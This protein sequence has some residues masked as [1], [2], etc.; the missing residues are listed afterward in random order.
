M[1]AASAR[2]HDILRV[3]IKSFQG[4][5]VQATTLHE[6]GIFADRAFALRDKESGKILSGKHARKG[7]RLLEFS[8]RF[9]REPVVGETLPPII[10][11]IAG[12]ECSTEDLAAFT[13]RCAEALDGDVELVVAGDAG[14]VY[15]TY[16]PEVDGLPLS[17]STIEFP[18]GLAEV[19]SFADLEPLHLL[20]TASIAHL[21]SLLP[22][23]EVTDARFRPSLVLD[24][25]DATGFVENDWVGRTATLGGATLALGQAAPRCVMT[26]RPQR[27]LPKD[28]RVLRTLVQENQQEF[29]GLQMPCLG[30]Y[31]KVTQ[32][33]PISVGD[34][35][36]IE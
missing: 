29:M 8:A 18:L 35:L 3:P 2:V 6:S 5:A 27:G 21:A 26:T 34:E 20:T 22:E 30:I 7:E 12:Q 13:R 14:H 25:G 16:W 36:K 32:P 31:A 15:D 1:T 23:S 4:E 9:S 28:I 33:G 19:G 17:D 10:A 24:T 11:T